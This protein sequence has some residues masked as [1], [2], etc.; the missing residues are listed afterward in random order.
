VVVYSTFSYRAAEAVISAHAPGLIDEIR[1]ILSAQSVRLGREAEKKQRNLSEQ[2]ASWFDP[3]WKRERPSEAIPSMK[4]DLWKEGIPV[5]IEIGHQRLV[6]PD[7]FKYLADYS[8]G[9]IPAGIMVVTNTPAAFG[10][11]WHCSL[12]STRLKIHAIREVY[13]VPTLVIPIDP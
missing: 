4:Y 7:F 13:L 9:F 12:Q 8:K 6:F 10:S 2:I 1:R 5:E 11:S 3:S